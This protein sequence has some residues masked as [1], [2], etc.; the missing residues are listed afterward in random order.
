MRSQ[1]AEP[2]RVL[3]L[4]PGRLRVHLPDWHGE[5]ARRIETCL[6]RV[7]GV[8]HVKAN[9]LTGNVLVRFDPQSTTSEAVLAAL[10]RLE[11]RLSARRRKADAQAFRAKALRCGV[12]GLVGHAVVDTVL[13]TLSFA[14][15]FGL[16]LATLAKLHLGLDILVWGAA[17]TP[18]LEDE[19]ET[20][21]RD[22]LAAP[23]PGA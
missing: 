1:E 20:A 6:G 16:P 7:R 3:S 11:G 13:Y 22:G 15:P 23:A 2:M 17:L 21:R 14:E 9:S 8:R 10:A 5:E 19:T 18:L 4:T 12:R